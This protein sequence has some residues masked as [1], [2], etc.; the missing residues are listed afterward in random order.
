M[1]QEHVTCFGVSASGDV[2]TH[3]TYLGSALA[4][5]LRKWQNEHP[6]AKVVRVAQSQ[7]ESTQK[8]GNNRIL[9]LLTVFY[10]M[11]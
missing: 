4:E 10:V 9:L 6:Q 8:D 7:S 5:S 1:A 2:D 11:E 3:D